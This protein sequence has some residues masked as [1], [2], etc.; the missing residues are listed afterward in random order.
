L[1]F[2]IGIGAF[3]RVGAAALFLFLGGISVGCGTRAG[4]DAR[5][6]RRAAQHRKRGAIGDPSSSGISAAIVLA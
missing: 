3:E 6:G 2:R 4:G 1:R 5:C